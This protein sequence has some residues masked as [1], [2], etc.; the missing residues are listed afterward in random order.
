[1]DPVGEGLQLIVAGGRFIVL[2]N[3]FTLEFSLSDTSNKSVLCNCPIQVYLVGDLKFYAQMSGR[4]DMSSAWCMWCMLHPSEWRTFGEN[5]DSIPEEE[6]QQWT[7]ELHYNHLNKIRNNH[8]KEPREKKGVVSEHIWSFI[9]P[10]KYIFP[11]LH[12][13]IG[14]VNMVLDNFY[15]FIE[16]RVEVLSQEEKVARNS[17][18]FAET[19]LQESKKKLGRVAE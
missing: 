16:D 10:K 6:K 13:E 15:G 14:V 11:Q 3:N 19:S 7:V 1:M 8:L 9:E 5:K 18:I 17:I 12:F 2:D 4:E